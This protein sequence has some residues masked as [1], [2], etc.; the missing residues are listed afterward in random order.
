MGHNLTW[1]MGRQLASFDGITYTYN[2]SGIR[3]SKTSNGVTTK[4]YLDGTNIIEQTDGTNTLHFY[5][6]SS[7][8][9]IGFNYAEN[10]YFYVK[11]QQGDITDIVDADGNVVASY[12]YDSWGAVISVSGSNLE[13]A[14]L[15]P[16]RYRSYY[17]DSDIQMYYLQTR[18]YDAN[19]CR[20]IN[21]DDV[22][23][24]DGADSEIAN[25]PFAYCENDA[26]NY[27][28]DY[29]STSRKKLNEFKN[30]YIK[31][32][33]SLTA[34]FV[35]LVISNINHVYLA[36]HEFAQ[37]LIAYAL[38]EKQY[39]ARL[40]EPCKKK[41]KKNQTKEIDVWGALYPPRKTSCF[42]WEVKPEG[43]SAKKQI[44]EY[45]SLCPGYKRGFSMN[46]IRVKI[47]NNLWFTVVFD[48]KGG[49]FYRFEK[50]NGKKITNKEVKKDIDYAKNAVIGIGVGIVIIICAGAIAAAIGGASV[51]AGGGVAL[52]T[53][54]VVA[55]NVS[56][57]AA[58]VATFTAA[59][60]R[61]RKYN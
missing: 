12:A 24:I 9:L 42:I 58:F 4:Y 39:E 2:E 46:K 33:I 14:N 49:A 51:A 27:I 5:Y 61:A 54:K 17:Y 8:E 44:N 34:L 11:N 41:A 43:T 35:S 15:N 57:A 7:S 26:I 53:I 32:S 38:H 22:H 28:D 21:C 10:D 20:F 47:I 37:V 59:M 30:N 52:T 36:F 19:V 23:Y 16:F 45:L 50:N 1:T 3:T 56:K 13:L 40:E 60:Q 6:D 18:Y 29:G 55:K 25:N 31:R 48:G